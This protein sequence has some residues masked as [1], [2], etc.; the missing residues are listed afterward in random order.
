MRHRGTDVAIVACLFL[1]GSV[2]SMI[3]LSL[4]TGLLSPVHIPAWRTGAVIAVALV[5]GPAM[6]VLARS[7]ERGRAWARPVGIAVL[8]TFTVAIG[9]FAF[10][11]A[12]SEDA[13][14]GA[15]YAV[16]FGPVVG[17]FTLAGCIG[18]ATR[19]SAEDFPSLSDYPS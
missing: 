19:G 7:L 4:L 5:V 17:G 18:L 1:G 13:G 2:L 8:A 15:G 10:M 16:L 6:L 9:L 12:T 3:P 11:V 14:D